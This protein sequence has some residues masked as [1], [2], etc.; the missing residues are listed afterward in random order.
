MTIALV[1]TFLTALVV[2][3]YDLIVLLSIINGVSTIL[4][5][6]LA[7]IAVL[8]QVLGI[9]KLK[10]S[11]S[12]QSNEDLVTLLLRQVTDHLDLTKLA[13][14]MVLSS[15]RQEHLSTWF[16]I[17]TEISTL[18]I[19]EFTLDLRRRNAKSPAS[20]QSASPLPALLFRANPTQGV[21]SVLGRMHESIILEMGESKDFVDVPVDG[22]ISVQTQ[23]HDSQISPVLGATTESTPNFCNSND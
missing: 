7:F 16:L 17:R 6:V 8:R 11:L 13:E 1:L 3:I 22:P 20:N 4:T 14:P 23:G 12:L 10:Q 19:C 9:W 18:L 2:Q 5:D 21:R 15:L